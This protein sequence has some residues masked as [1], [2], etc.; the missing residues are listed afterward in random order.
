MIYSYNTKKKKTSNVHLPAGPPLTSRPAPPRAFLDTTDFRTPL[1]AAHFPTGLGLPVRRGPTP[2]PLPFSRHIRPARAIVVVA[3]LSSL[4][5]C[6]SL[7]LV[8][9]RARCRRAS[10]PSRR[11]LT[12]RP[13][14]TRRRTTILVAPTQPTTATP[15]PSATDTLPCVALSI[16]LPFPFP[17][18][19]FP[20]PRLVPSGVRRLSR[21]PPSPLDRPGPLRPQPLPSAAS[22]AAKVFGATG[23][24]RHLPSPLSGLRY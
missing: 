14:L 13:Y 3:S 12:L 7:T 17:V 23:L 19:L 18:R 8:P 20:C 1:Q 11:L 2:C 22:F 6:L 16:V 21:G 5:R 4:P 24:V 15:G 10:A 9:R